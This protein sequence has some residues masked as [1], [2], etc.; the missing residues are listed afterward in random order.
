[1]LEGRRVQKSKHNLPEFRRNE[2]FFQML[3]ERRV[4]K[5]SIICLN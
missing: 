5:I 3:A 1:M 4:Q 2:I